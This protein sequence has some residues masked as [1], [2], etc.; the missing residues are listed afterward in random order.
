MQIRSDELDE[1]WRIFTPLLHTLER[2]RVPPIPYKF[3]SRGPQASDDLISKL[4]Y[5]YTATSEN[6]M[7]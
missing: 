3:G 6:W 2:D 5:K 1:A 7:T 4:G